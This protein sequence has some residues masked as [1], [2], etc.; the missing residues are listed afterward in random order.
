LES[1]APWVCQGLDLDPLVAGA[2][3]GN[4]LDD[5]HVTNADFDFLSMRERTEVRV[6]GGTDIHIITGG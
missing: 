2:G 1:V 6:N 3:N 4:R 5:A